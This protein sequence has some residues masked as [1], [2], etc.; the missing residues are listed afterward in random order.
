MHIFREISKMLSTKIDFFL[1]YRK[2]IKKA[3]KILKEVKKWECTTVI[4]SG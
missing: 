4:E 2:N 1:F 3:S